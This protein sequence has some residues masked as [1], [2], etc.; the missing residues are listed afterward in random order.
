MVQDT[1]TLLRHCYVC[2][3]IESGISPTDRIIVNPS[4]S[5]AD[6]DHVQVQP[7]QKNGKGAS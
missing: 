3:E 1:A 7:Q 4:D 2:N 5:I 6:G